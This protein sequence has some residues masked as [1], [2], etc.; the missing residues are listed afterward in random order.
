MVI[1]SGKSVFGGIAIGKLYDYAK[2]DSM[3][4]RVNI[5]DPEA[6]IERYHKAKDLTR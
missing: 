5:E 2:D 6:E 1:Y 4:K 3:V